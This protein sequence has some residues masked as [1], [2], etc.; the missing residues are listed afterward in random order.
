VEKIMTSKAGIGQS[1]LDIHVLALTRNLAGPYCTMILGDMGAEVLKIERPGQGD[2]T[3]SWIPPT[4][5]G[6]ST[7]YLSANRNKQSVA[8]NLNTTEGVRIVQKLA[9]K[10]D[11][12]VESFR[13]GSLDKRGLGYENLKDKNPRLIYC[14]ISGYGND[15]PLQNSPGYDPIMQASTGIMDLTGEPDQEPV[16]LPIAVND[17]G[18]GMWAVIGILSALMTR[19][20]T[21]RGCLVE[22]SL[23][24]TAAWWMNY[25]VTSYLATGVAPVR[26]GTGTPFIAPYEVYPAS[27]E[28]LLVCVGNDHLFRVFVEELEIPELAKDERFA[29]NPMRVENRDELRRIIIEPLQTR[30]AAE[31]EARFKARA[32]PC[33]RILTVADLVQNDQF[34]ALNL[35]KS[36]PHPSIPDLRLI[37]LP[38]SQN[39]ERAAPHNSPP[40]LGEHTNKIL[41][42]L[43]YSEDEIGELRKNCVVS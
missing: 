4:W 25:H 17:M 9:Y 24:E 23:Y 43:G 32:I 33:S 35:L 30:T 14:S 8:V 31:W 37:D 7:T 12:L 34:R 28:G 3:R 11:I 10:T 2:D 6:E 39:K 29:T 13:P 18:A 41:I 16:R 5:N 36:F 20:A 40:L 42:E 27:D 1:L 15:G 21:G 22:T 26:C 38:V 19:Q